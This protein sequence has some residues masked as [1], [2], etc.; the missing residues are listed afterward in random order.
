M[1]DILSAAKKASKEQLNGYSYSQKEVELVG[2]GKLE[3]EEVGWSTASASAYTRKSVSDW[4]ARDML[5]YCFIKYKNLIGQN[6]PVSYGGAQESLKLTQEELKKSIGEWPSNA[7]T[8]FYID[9]FFR[10]KAEDLIAK[11]NFLAFKMLRYENIVHDFIK[12]CREQNLSF[13]TK[14]RIEKNT[15]KPVV[16][17]TEEG[18]RLSMEKGIVS[19]LSSYGIFICYQWLKNK[20]NQDKNTSINKICQSVIEYMIK[21]NVD[22][23]F[24]LSERLGPYPSVMKPEF[25]ELMELLAKNTGEPFTLIT[26]EYKDAQS[27]FPFL[28]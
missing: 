8:K 9:W 11:N 24:T 7:L 22:E 18:M 15:Y 13:K 12:F 27:R 2:T 10:E 14:E 19:F 20:E 25:T 1:D 5:S 6:W 17:M 21:E 3:A 26:A 23:L 16:H 4:N 28:S